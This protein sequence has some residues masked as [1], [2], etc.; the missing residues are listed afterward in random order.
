MAWLARQEKVASYA[1]RIDGGEWQEVPVEG[2]IAAE[3]EA[4]F[5]GPGHREGEPAT[6]AFK[7]YFTRGIGYDAV[8]L[9]VEGKVLLQ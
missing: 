8:R 2:F 5:N 3:K 9:S 4:G 6:Y 7:G 1:I